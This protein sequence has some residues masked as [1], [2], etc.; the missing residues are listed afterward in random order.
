MS[1]QTILNYSPNFDKKKRDSKK[2]RFLIFH[3][4]GMKKE[5][6]AISRLTDIKSEVSSHYLIKNNG[7]IITLV[8]EL[9]IAWHSGVSFWK[10]YQSLN[11][12]SIGIEIS[13]PGHNFRYKNFSKKQ[14]NSILL[15]SKYLIKKYKIKPQNIL[16]HSDIAPN[17]KKD[18]GEKF[19]WEYLS[20]QKVGFWHKLD[21]KKL[22]KFRNLKINIS[23][24]K[25]FYKNILKIGYSEKNFK[26]SKISK[27]YYAK[28]LTKAFQ[29][30]FRPELIN[31][32]IDLECLFISQNLAKKLN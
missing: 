17:R 13:N 4:T 23:K 21:K 8:P 31:G 12:N 16:G 1:F 28:I 26:N 24:E 10:N 11:K 14:I 29:R 30:R 3:Y 18:P 9:Y 6:E 25:L 20:K 15:L 5:S 22:V 7:Q 19:P 27:V 2:I 32:K